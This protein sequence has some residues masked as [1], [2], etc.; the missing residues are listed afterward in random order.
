MFSFY[1]F[2]WLQQ[3]MTKLTSSQLLRLEF[4]KILVKHFLL[5]N[6]KRIPCIIF[7]T[8]K[9]FYKLDSTRTYNQIK[10]IF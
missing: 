3:G 8:G 2:N 10:H 4:V 7:N 9:L 1:L 5:Y 6:S